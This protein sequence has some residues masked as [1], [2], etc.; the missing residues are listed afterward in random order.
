MP[1]DTHYVKWLIGVETGRLLWDQR[2]RWDPTAQRSGSSDAPRKA[3]SRN[4]N[5]SLALQKSLI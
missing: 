1:V 4:G 3:P 2:H 5:Q